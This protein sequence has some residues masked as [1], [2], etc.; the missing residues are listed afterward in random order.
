MK[1][2]QSLEVRNNRVVFK[3]EL[4]R[5]ITI[6]KGDSAT[7]KTTLVNMISLYDRFGA[8]SGIV[9]KCSKRCFVL[10]NRNWELILSGSKDS[11]IFIDEGEDFITGPKFASAVKN[12]DN[13]YVIIT[14]ENLFDLPISVDAIYGMCGRKYFKLKKTYNH[15]YRI[16]PEVKLSNDMQWRTVS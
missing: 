11:I 6:I 10:D 2:K 4:E 13:Y 1:G 5:N 14:R 9:L 15:L 7:G 16:Y 12:S 8:S 3:F